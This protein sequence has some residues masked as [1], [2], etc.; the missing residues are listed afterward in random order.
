MTSAAEVIGARLAGL[1]PLTALVGDRIRLLRFS[2]HET[3]PAV[4]VFQVAA[5]T[6]MHGRG[7]VS[8]RRAVVQVDTVAAD[9]GSGNPYAAAQAIDAVIFGDGRGGG[10]VGFSGAVGTA[11]VRGVFPTDVREE[12]DPDVPSVVR[13]SRDWIV[14]WS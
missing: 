12:F 11:I 14:W 7:P 13:V 2:Q 1:A 10:L 6:T 8:M 4:R 3:W 5:E 9:D